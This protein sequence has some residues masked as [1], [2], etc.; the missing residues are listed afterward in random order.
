ML[1]LAVKDI[2]SHYNSIIYIFKNLSRDMRR[3]KND[4]NQVS[5]KENNVWN[6]KYS[7]GVNRKLDIAEIKMNELEDRAIATVQYIFICWWYGWLC[8]KYAK[9]NCISIYYINNK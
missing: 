7:D 6:E 2:K 3:Y 4:P 9:I 5:R 1:E 8:G